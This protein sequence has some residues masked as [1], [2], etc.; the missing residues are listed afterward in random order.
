MEVY[1]LIKLYYMKSML[2]YRKKKIPSSIS[3][4]T[5]QPINQL[6]YLQTI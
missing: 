2:Y 4:L 5:N 1:M 6:E 3:I